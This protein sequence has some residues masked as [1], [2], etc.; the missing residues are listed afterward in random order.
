M[1]KPELVTWIMVAIILIIFISAFI[2]VFEEKHCNKLKVLIY[3]NEYECKSTCYT[4][5]S[6]INMNHLCSERRLSC[7][8]NKTNKWFE[9]EYDKK[10][11]IVID[12]ED[13]ICDSDLNG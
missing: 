6:I 4:S 2:G 12:N 1:E 3:G 10:S 5:P 13:I 11:I 9:T 8:N 7:L